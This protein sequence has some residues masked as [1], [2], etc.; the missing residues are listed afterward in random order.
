MKW[1]E[2]VERQLV[3]RRNAVKYAPLALL[4]RQVSTIAARPADL[5]DV[6]SAPR[7]RLAAFY[8]RAR[9]GRQAGE[10]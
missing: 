6:E 2:V 8:W 3:S 1:R 9:H 5:Q 7:E 10:L 4:R